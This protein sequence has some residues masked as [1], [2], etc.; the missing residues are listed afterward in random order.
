MK[1]YA[2]TAGVAALMMIGGAAQADL[3]ITG[4]FDAP[5]P[6]GLPKGIEVYA[7]E[8][9]ADLSV[10]GVE[11]VGNGGVSNGVPDA[12]LPAVSLNAGDFYYLEH[13]DGTAIA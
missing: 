5:L 12:P 10:Y 1:Y 4:V 8:N 7:T 9:I 6:G 3:I 11:T 13:G 2:T